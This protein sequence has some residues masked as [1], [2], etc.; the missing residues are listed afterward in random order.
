MGLEQDIKIKK[1]NPGPLEFED[2]TF[3]IVFS[4]DSIVHIQDKER[5]VADIFRILKPGGYFVASDW[6]RSHD[7]QPSAEMMRYLDL[8]DLGFDMASPK[9]YRVALE[10]AGYEN[11]VLLNRN[12]WYLDQ[13]RKE[14]NTLSKLLFTRLKTF[15]FFIFPS[16]GQPKAAAMT[17]HN[18]F[19]SFLI[20]L[21]T[22][23]SI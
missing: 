13:A 17:T 8:E 23:S 11:I 10:R 12:E 3:D 14:L 9:R 19:F 2:M 21:A 15:V 6:L 7:G 16:Y 20:S 22:F 5:L 18:F 4:K 1:A